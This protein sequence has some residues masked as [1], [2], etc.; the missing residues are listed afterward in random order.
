MKKFYWK[1]YLLLPV[2]AVLYGIYLF[3]TTSLFIDDMPYDNLVSRMQN[4]WGY[5]G[6][7]FILLAAMIIYQLQENRKWEYIYS[8]PKRK[9]DLYKEMLSSLH[10]YTILAGM[11]Y[12]IVYG[13]RCAK[14]SGWDELSHI[15]AASILSCLIFW[16][17]CVL[18]EIFLLAFRYIWQGIFAICIG[19]FMI[20]PVFLGNLGYILQK[21]NPSKNW[22]FIWQQIFCSPKSGLRIPL[23]LNYELFVEQGIERKYLAGWG[24]WCEHYRLILTIAAIFISFLL[25]LFLRAAK[26][27]YCRLDLSQKCHLSRM[28]RREN[29]WI[30]IG[31]ASLYL[32][33][34]ITNLLTLKADG[35][36]ISSYVV[37]V[38]FIW[39]KQDL[40]L[41]I[42][43]I[44]TGLGSLTVCMLF[45]ASIIVCTSAVWIIQKIRRGIH[46]R[47][48]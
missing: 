40:N 2:F 46:A 38:S 1:Y 41:T 9:Q 25:V 14:A 8:F 26:R 44:G 43:K 31:I 10:F 3:D 16:L 33:H 22:V 28:T 17:K 18:A 20:L 12:G 34:G 15:V 27:I 21:L 4:G 42:E 23:E 7:I 29:E 35:L 47:D 30:V 24:I 37:F 48:I 6:F 39:P 19:E 13:I 45:L 36:E 5:L 32:F 11:I